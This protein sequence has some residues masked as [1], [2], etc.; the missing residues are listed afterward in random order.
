MKFDKKKRESITVASIIIALYL[1]S[2]W[3]PIIGFVL[4]GLGLVAM[5]IYVIDESPRKLDCPFCHMENFDK[6]PLKAHLMHG[7]CPEWNK[8]RLE[9]SE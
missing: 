6:I 9:E 4:F 7:A 1:V 5:F 3:I 8:T 2:A